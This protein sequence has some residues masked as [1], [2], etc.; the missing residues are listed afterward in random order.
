MFGLTKSEKDK[1]PKPMAKFTETEM[2]NI[3]E[4]ER[5]LRDSKKVMMMLAASLNGTLNDLRE[6]Y[7]L[8]EEF[9]LDRSTG[10]ISKKEKKDG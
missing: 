9:N 6:K 1:G 10:E 4:Q 2:L 3:N 7:S 5:L 8:P